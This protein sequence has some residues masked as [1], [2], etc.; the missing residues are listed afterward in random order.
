MAKGAQAERSTTAAAHESKPGT[1][2]KVTKNDVKLQQVISIFGTEVPP[3][4]VGHVCQGLTCILVFS[5]LFSSHILTFLGFFFLNSFFSL[6][7]GVCAFRY[8]FAKSEN[9]GLPPAI[10]Q[11]VDEAIKANAMG[12]IASLPAVQLPGTN[13]PTA[14]ALQAR[15]SASMT[16]LNQT[17]YGYAL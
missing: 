11:Q 17:R 9:E 16:K 5:L 3:C 1:R 15:K 8:G 6:Q 13:T 4:L 10:R 14:P 12:G 2:H 7:S